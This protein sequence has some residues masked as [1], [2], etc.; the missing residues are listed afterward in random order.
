MTDV[1]IAGGGPAGALTALLLARA[2][3]RVRVFERAT[4]PRHKLCG[5]TLNPGAMAVLAR[6]LEIAPLLAKSDA[7]DGMLVTGPGGVRVEG[8]Y[9]CGLTGRAVTRRV[10]DQWLLSEASSA[11]ARIDEGAVVKGAAVEAGTVRG[12]LVQGRQG[13][14]GVERA[15]VVVAADGRRSSLALSR[16]WSRQPERPR[17]WAIGAYLSDVD[18][19]T[20]LGEMHIRRGHYIGVAPVPDDLI[21]V[22]LVV[23]YQPGTGTSLTPRDLMNR[24]TA[25]AELAPRFSRA[26]LVDAPV[27][28]GPMA[29][30]NHAAGEPGLLLAGD[31]AGFI[32]PMTGDGLCLALV[33]AEL[34]AAVTLDVL[35]GRL[36]IGR[37]HLELLRR[38]RA[39]FGAKWRF[40]RTLRSLVASPRGVAA[41]AAATRIV[42]SLF[43]WMVRYAGD[44]P[45]ASVA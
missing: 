38:R 44:C 43:Q 39:A 37:A 14:P 26:R 33:S 29:V 30:D 19:L 8:R 18:G 6:H 24:V 21:N 4:F 40:N 20:R 31:A 36:S 41:A 13:P 34:A 27:M 12:V 16:G 35:A 28:L 15:R 11:G 3:A 23:P 5:D 9:P 45:K 17:R 32:D 25:D 7:I 1:V 22:C 2:G 42:P 10:F